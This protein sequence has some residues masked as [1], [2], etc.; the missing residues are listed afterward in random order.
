MEGQ[1]CALLAA[2]ELQ[3]PCEGLGVDAHAHG[4]D[5]E[6]AAEHIVP[7]EDI[8]VERP[9]VVIGRAAIVGLAG[10]Q[11]A[12]DLHDE[13]GLC[14][15]QIGALAL[16]GI[17]DVGEHVLQLLGGDGGHVA[18]ELDVDA[19]ILAVQAVAHVADALHDLP[20]DA[21]QRIQRAILPADDL[22]PV[23]LIHVDGVQVVQRFVPADGVHIGIDALAHAEVV[24]LQGEA[25][26][27]GQRV[28]HLALLAHGGHVEGDGALVAV[29]VVVQTGGLL[30]EQRCGHPAQVQR[31]GQ[32]L[33]EVVLDEFNG[34]L[35]VVH[36]QRRAVALGNVNLVHV[37][38][39]VVSL[40]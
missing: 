20:G 1:V 4:G 39:P 15:F 19:G 18:A 34:H 2:S 30:D 31:V 6:G 32:L 10:L 33:L 23:P 37:R 22:L 9:V 27:L 8:A 25:L 29:E 28:H 21:L 38:P 5:F 7:E 16:G 24:L 3:L 12:A 14:L 35:H 36:A 17:G 40:R 13:R 26:P 11:L